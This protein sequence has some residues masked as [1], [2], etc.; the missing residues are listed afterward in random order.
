MGI[1]YGF[2]A[3]LENDEF[4]KRLKAIQDKLQ[5]WEDT[6]AFL[7]EFDVAEQIRQSNPQSW[8]NFSDEEIFKQA[9]IIN[10]KIQ[11]RIWEPDRQDIHD[12]AMK[13]T[14]QQYLSAMPAFAAVIA[15]TFNPNSLVRKGV[16]AQT[17]NYY[18]NFLRSENPNI[19]DQEVEQ[20]WG[21]LK[22]NEGNFKAWAVDRLEKGEEA[23][24][25]YLEDNPQAMATL[26]WLA[27]KSL[28]EEGF[29]SKLLQS[30]FENVMT[31]LVI[32]LSTNFEKK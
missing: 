2:S 20:Q 29:D 24:E 22:G 11:E 13:T 18:S 6:D 8:S 1:R 23:Y 16:E 26:E 28:T 32:G 27:G 4:K 14:E 10:P 25:K 30:I 19:T 5:S 21:E 15:D 17:K 7:T 9:V 31:S 12:V 3:P